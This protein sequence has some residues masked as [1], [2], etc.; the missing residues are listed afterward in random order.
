MRDG[1]A[2]GAQRKENDDKRRTTISL[3]L[4]SIEKQSS[5]QM[6][7]NKE[8]EKGKKKL[9]HSPSFPS[10]NSPFSPLLLRAPH[11]PC[12]PSPPPSPAAPTHPRSPPRYASCCSS[13]AAFGKSDEDGELETE[14][15]L[16]S[17]FLLFP[18]DVDWR[19]G[20]PARPSPPLCSRNPGCFFRSTT[21]RR[22]LHRPRP[23]R[24][25]N[26][27]LLPHETLSLIKK[28]RIEKT[29]PSVVLRRRASY[30]SPVRFRG[31][32]QRRGRRGH[33]PRR[34]V[35]GRPCESA[36]GGFNR[37]DEAP[38]SRLGARTEF[39]PLKC[40]ALYFRRCRR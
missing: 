19:R 10:S 23:T 38:D 14:E 2:E 12:L 25:R 20:F 29:A 31:P 15:N 26:K 17:F 27:I 21:G 39:G 7:K 33:R 4:L 36:P 32:G 22:S 18:F 9:S 8:R 40:R 6:Q 28:K 34:Q 5:S 1:E 13:S 3:L 35:Q 30:P 11:K 37:R 16:E 24:L